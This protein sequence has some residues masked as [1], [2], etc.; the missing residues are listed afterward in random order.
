MTT[1][2]QVLGAAVG[3]PFL[4]MAGAGRVLGQSGMNILILG[5]T[6]FIGPHLVQHA[7]DRGHKITLFNRGRSNPALFPSAEKLVGDRDG[8][9]TAL[10]GRRWDAVIDNSGYTSQQVQSSLTY[11]QD[12]C[13]L[14]LFT[15]TRSVYHEFTA[16]LMN[17]DAPLGPRNIPES[18]WEGYGPNKVLA[19]RVVMDGFG[20]R[21]LITRPSI[22]V[23]P[24]D[25]TDRFT[26]WVDRIDDGGDILV[27]GEPTDPVQY[28]D[29]RD[30]AEFYVHLLE[31]S[32]TGIYNTEGP[33]TLLGAAG[34]VDGIKA[35]TATPS[36]FHWVDWDFL[37][38]EGE[39]PQ[40]S[41]PFWQPPR[42]R[43]LNYG[44]M[45][46]RRAMAKGLTFRPLAVTARDTLEW[47][48]TRSAAEQAELK[49][50]LSRARE[51]ELLQKWGAA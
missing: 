23:G 7:M 12:A 32:V 1:R 5:G 39:T 3:A 50:G 22:I 17:E 38:E 40:D 34:L 43:Y 35:V 45:D 26:Y 37:I 25:R 11:L 8:D 29:V 6:G 14:Y 19:E 41:L 4:G 46:N 20:A 13:D 16:D 49:V 33:A 21:A 48:R 28:I 51:A 24:G 9:L 44:R 27:Q 47:H 30:L 2:R 31:G 15:S 36:R 18:Q 10:R 42:G